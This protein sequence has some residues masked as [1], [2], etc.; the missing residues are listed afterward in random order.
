MIDNVTPVEKIDWDSPGKRIYHVP[1]THDGSW[2]R[3][4]LPV[5]V[6][7]GQKPG[8]TVVVIGGTHGDEY[9]GPVAA[10][11]I[12]HDLSPEHISGRVIVIPVLNVPAFQHA[13]RESPL[14][15]GNMNRAFPGDAQGTITYR[16]ARFMTDEV[17]KRADVVLDL[18]AAGHEMEIV[19]CASF[20]SIKDPD[21]FEQH[22]QTALAF[23]TPFVM[24]YTDNLGTGLLTSEVE[25]M[26]KIAIGGEFG[27]GA[28]TDFEG[29]RYAYEGI[30]NVLRLHNLLDE[31]VQ[32]F[33]GAAKRSVLISN[34]DV[35]TYVTAPVSGI[36]ESIV[37][38]SSFVQEGDPVVRIHN[39]E[40]LEEQGHTIYANQKGYVIF[41]RFRAQ[42]TQG[43]MVMVIADE[44][45][46]E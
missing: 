9:E 10:K 34:T 16:M 44:L 38:I 14:D 19:R 40:L 46:S 23:G 29:I 3:S 11:R 22:K 33:T 36:V 15:G 21:L 27:Y 43:D 39:F 37:P 6:I 35:D 13:Q 18:H 45:K 42:V 17:L 24:I 41:R 1:F 5:C 32:L 30:F 7:T 8:K 20:H 12:I 2:K 25:K 31:P 28:S 26:G 4:R